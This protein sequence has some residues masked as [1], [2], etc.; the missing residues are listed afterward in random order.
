LLIATGLHQV[1]GKI[2][3]RPSDI[4]VGSVTAGQLQ[5]LL[6]V[7]DCLLAIAGR[8]PYTAAS[9][10]RETASTQVPLDF[11]QTK[12]AIGLRQR[13]VTLGP[14]RSRERILCHQT[15]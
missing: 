15:R 10:Q 5:G 11:G 12:R 13:F 6:E 4:L 14:N 8:A 2:E 7:A 1:E 9:V 3:R